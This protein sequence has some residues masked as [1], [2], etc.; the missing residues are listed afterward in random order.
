MSI[1]SVARSAATLKKIVVKLEDIFLKEAVRF[2]FIVITV[3]R[4][5]SLSIS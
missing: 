5:C 1:D 2:A 3:A 4:A